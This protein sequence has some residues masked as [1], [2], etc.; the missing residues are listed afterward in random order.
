MRSMNDQTATSYFLFFDPPKSPPCF[1]SDLQLLATWS[2]DLNDTHSHLIFT[3]K[4]SIH[5][6]ILTPGR[7]SY[8]CCC[9]FFATN[10]HQTHTQTKCRQFAQKNG[11]KVPRVP[12][13]TLR[14]ISKHIS[15]LF[16]HPPICR[17][18][19]FGHLPSTLPDT[20]LIIRT[21]C[22][23]AICIIN[24]GCLPS[25]SSPS[26]SSSA[27]V[28]NVL[29][30]ASFSSSFSVPPPLLYFIILFFGVFLF[31]WYSLIPLV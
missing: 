13:H 9:C 26:S 2:P 11:Q 17:H 3:F 19:L 5:P 12:T 18:S 7:W 4:Q 24:N 14:P 8:Y 25:P 21:W 1:G 28:I 29:L 6:H 15:I 23:L 22:Q 30:F 31:L 27:H 16:H 10:H 20:V